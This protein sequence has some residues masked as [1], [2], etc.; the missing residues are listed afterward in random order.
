MLTTTQAAALLGVHPQT[1]RKLVRAGILPAYRVGH[2]YRLHPTDLEA[3]LRGSA[4]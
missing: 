2:H 4:A 1:L 3:F